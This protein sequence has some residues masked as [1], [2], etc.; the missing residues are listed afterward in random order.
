ML[1]QV[2]LPNGRP[3]RVRVDGGLPLDIARDERV[4]LLDAPTGT[5]APTLLKTETSPTV[6][7][8]GTAIGVFVMLSIG[9]IVA[10]VVLWVEIDK[11]AS[12]ATSS[13]VPSI[14]EVGSFARTV[15]NSTATTMRNVEEMSAVSSDLLMESARTVRHSLN[16]TNGMLRKAQDV[17]AHPPTI[18]LGLAG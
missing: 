1:G 4:Q 2:V 7:V 16:A 17:L 9:I 6:W 3:L 15:M 14:A 13:D 5:S 12:V 11:L 10:V 18:Q 8:L